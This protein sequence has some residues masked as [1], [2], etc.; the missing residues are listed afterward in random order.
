[1]GCVYTFKIVLS[2]L[3]G[4]IT[5]RGGLEVVMLTG[6]H[7]SGTGKGAFAPLEFFGHGQTG[8]CPFGIFRVWALDMRA[9]A[10]KRAFF[11]KKS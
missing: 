5:L 6:T 9:R 10:L 3:K 1:M 11:K 8:I 2:C 7:L 4:N